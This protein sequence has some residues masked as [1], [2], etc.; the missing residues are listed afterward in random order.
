[1]NIRPS[2][3]FTYL[4]LIAGVLA[5]VLAFSSNLLWAGAMLV[6]AA[7]ADV[8]DGRVAR[9]LGHESPFGMHLDSLVDICAFGFAPVMIAFVISNQSPFVV[10]T[11]ILYL[12]AGVFR[13]ARFQVTKERAG[14]QGMPITVNGVLFPL[15]F[16]APNSF[17]ISAYFFIAA[18]L[19][20]STMKVPKL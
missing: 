2:D 15:V 12:G 18:A 10:A 9:K 5:V 14:F 3:A 17:V 8:L 20:V 16:F 13:L 19:M 4:S 7:C 11:G 1:M 6:V